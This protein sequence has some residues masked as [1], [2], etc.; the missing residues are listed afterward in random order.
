MKNLSGA[1]GLFFVVFIALSLGQPVMANYQLIPEDFE[2][3]VKTRMKRMECIVT[4]RLNEEVKFYLNKYIFKHPSFTSKMLGNAALYFPVFETLLEK[5][6]MPKEL[7]A[8]SIL[9]SWLDPAATSRVG[10]G[11]LWQLMPGT[12]KLYG[13]EVSSQVDERRDIYK[14][15]EAALTLLKNLFHLYKDWGLSLAAYNAGPVRVNQAIKKAGVENPQFWTIA[16]YLP[17]ETQHFVP[18]F[19]AFTYLINFYADHE[20]YPDFPELDLQFIAPVKVY[21]RVRLQEIAS[22]TGLSFEVLSK[23]NPGYRNG[24]IPANKKGYNL[25]L[26]QRVIAQV[27]AFLEMPDQNLRRQ[28]LGNA[29]VSDNESVASG[30]A[31]SVQYAETIY[32]VEEGDDLDFIAFKFELNK[33]RIMLWNHLTTEYLSVGQKLKIFIPIESYIEKFKIE[34]SPLE[35]VHL[36]SPDDVIQPALCS[37]FDMALDLIP[38]P[39]NVLCAAEF[40]HHTVRLGETWADIA[41]QYPGTTINEIAQANPNAT[42]VIGRKLLIPIKFSEMDENLSFENLSSKR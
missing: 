5:N 17:K 13:L 42:L 9:E 30:A 31:E 27:S 4:P 33:L 8:L 39:K 11:G 32:E 16:P 7:K 22:L 15:T 20:I 10:A 36:M 34:T 6:E 29:I 2:F 38:S 21:Q 24:I 37:D 25:V 1:V 14:S 35:C 3:A 26:P 23:L 18:K 28:F 12:A 19:I 40:Y 41:M